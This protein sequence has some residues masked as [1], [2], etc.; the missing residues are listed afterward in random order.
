MHI[1]VV[2]DKQLY[3]QGVAAENSRRQGSVHRAPVLQVS[4]LQR[5]AVPV[6]ACSKHESKHSDVAEQT[7]T[8]EAV[9]VSEQE[10]LLGRGW[11]V[12]PPGVQLLQSPPRDTEGLVHA[13]QPS[14]LHRWQVAQ[15]QDVRLRRENCHDTLKQQRQLVG[16]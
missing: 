8:H 14:K 7:S 2:L 13:R 12:A 1:R 11:C 16:R 5:R 15:H 9:A 4:V 3:C 10:E 6:H